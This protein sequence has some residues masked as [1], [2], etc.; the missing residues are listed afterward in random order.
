L[1]FSAATKLI[2]VCIAGA[3]STC[4]W[5]IFRGCDLLHVLTAH[6]TQ[7]LMD[8][9]NSD[10]TAAVFTGERTGAASELYDVRGFF[11][12]ADRTESAK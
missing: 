1:Q 12:V 4:G 8:V 2:V 5:L 6:I 3:L 11:V 9:G 10:S 7:I